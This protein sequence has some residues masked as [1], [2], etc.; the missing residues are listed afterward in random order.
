[1]VAVTVDRSAGRNQE[2]LLRLQ[3]T[4]DRQCSG[5]HDRSSLQANLARRSMYEGVDVSGLNDTQSSN[6]SWDF[7][8]RLR[9]TPR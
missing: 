6:M 8:K 3:R 7:L 4:D 9:D 1:V 2:T 5:C